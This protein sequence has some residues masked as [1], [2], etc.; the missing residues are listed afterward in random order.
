MKAKI[1]KRNLNR[2]N[3]VVLLM[4]ILFSCK[5]LSFLLRG[6]TSENGNS[7]YYTHSLHSFRTEN[8]IK[9]NK[10]VCKNHDCCYIDN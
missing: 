5:T 2:E 6:I 4:I 1:P 9:S 7:Y 3:K 10:T 8:K